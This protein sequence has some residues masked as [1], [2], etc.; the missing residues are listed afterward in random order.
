MAAGD[1]LIKISDLAQSTGLCERYKVGE[2]KTAPGTGMSFCVFATRIGSAPQGSGLDATAKLVQCTAR[3]QIPMLYQPEADID[4]KMLN[5]ADAILGAI[6]ASFT[7]GGVARNVDLLGEQGDSPE[8]VFGYINMDNT[9][10]RIADLALRVV[11]ADE[12]TQA[13]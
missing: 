8:W 5:A 10:F 4:P 3:L 13:E 2:W 11:L 12:W 7:L 9:F 6:S 1:V